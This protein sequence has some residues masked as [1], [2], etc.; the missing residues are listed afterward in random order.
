MLVRHTHM[1]ERSVSVVN[2]S[3][4]MGA[5]P[6]NDL[7]GTNWR[8]KYANAFQKLERAIQKEQEIMTAEGKQISARL[9]HLKS[10]HVHFAQGDVRPFVAMLA[11]R[12]NEIA[13]NI[14]AGNFQSCKAEIIERLKVI[15]EL[16]HDTPQ[17]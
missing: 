6:G 16:S 9:E 13:H 3:G 12:S 8:T 15:M 10:V 11:A 5:T 4:A 1:G 7:P 17:K 14:T 2:T